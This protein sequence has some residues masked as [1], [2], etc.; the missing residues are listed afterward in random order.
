[1]EIL[2]YHKLLT[3]GHAQQMALLRSKITDCNNTMN[4]LR[5][6]SSKLFQDYIHIN[7]HDVYS[8]KLMM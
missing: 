1:M 8:Q 4:A 5:N 7:I 3:D 2:D 6:N